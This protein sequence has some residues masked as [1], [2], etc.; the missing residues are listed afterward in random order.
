MPTGR[1]VNVSRAETPLVFGGDELS[2]TVLPG[3]G[4]RLHRLDAFGVN[5]L[6]TPPDTRQ[7]HRDPF[8]WGAYH[9]A[10]WCNRLDCTLTPFG[11]QV[12]DLRPNFADGTAIHGQVFAKPWVV[13][14]DGACTVD[15]GG[16]GWP[17]TYRLRLGITVDGASLQLA[18][19]LT[20]TS[21]DPMPAGVG[22]HPWFRKPAQVRIP[23]ARVFPANAATTPLPDPVTGSFDLRGQGSELA[24]DVDGTW[25]DLDSPDVEVTWPGA[26]V[27]AAL[28]IDGETQ[29]VV[30]A[31]PISIDA[32][33]LEPQT[34]APA[35]LR[36]LLRGEPYGM[37]PLDPEESLR[38]RLRYEF[39][40]L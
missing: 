36:R 34:H 10:P 17:W 6:R 33:A 29:V 2:V 14:D 23:A 1:T 19:E 27:A 26:G 12:V 3:A 31:N 7:H 37:A 38:F 22:L 20:N 11:S 32:F 28:R 5:L 40:R 30:A 25:V 8:F 4:A 21:A 13:D 24:P 9:M 18:Y 35:G 15:G 16:E 39:S